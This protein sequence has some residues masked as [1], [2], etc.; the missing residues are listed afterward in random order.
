MNKSPPGV[1]SIRAY[2]VRLAP[3]EKVTFFR[4]QV[5]EVYII[6]RIAKSVIAVC[7]KDL[8]VLTDAFY[9]CEADNSV[10]HQFS[11]RNINT[12]SKRKGYEI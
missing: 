4:L 6:L 8:K 1:L 5:V 3:P 12:L 7:G 9:G 2:T 11:P 10:Q